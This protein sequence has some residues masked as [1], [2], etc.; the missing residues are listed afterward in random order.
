VG[1]RWYD[2]TVLT[3]H[4]PSFER[5]FAGHVETGRPGV[6]DPAIATV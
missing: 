3:D 4:D 2:V 6:T 1:S 5:R